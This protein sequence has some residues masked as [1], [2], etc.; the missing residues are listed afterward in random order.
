MKNRLRDN[1]RRH[2][3]Y[4]DHHIQKWLLVALVVMECALIALAM[5]ALH[6]ALSDLVEENMYRIHFSAQPDQLLRFLAEGVK[7]LIGIGV[8]N[9]LALIL[10]DRIWAAYIGS[11]LR[12][13]DALIEDTQQ[14][15][16]TERAMTRTHDVLDQA[17]AWRAVEAGRM[18]KLRT[19]IGA[20]PAALPQLPNERT[21]ARNMLLKMHEAVA[22]RGR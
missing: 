5:W 16:F 2:I 21:Q 7:I 20:L 13:L 17:L 1:E 4:V 9:L 14:L 12:K 11:I 8:V 3:H 10:A 6:G 22:S 15:D 18:R 19:C